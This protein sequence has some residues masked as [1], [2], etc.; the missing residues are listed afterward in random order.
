M[1]SG[2]DWYK[3]SFVPEAYRHSIEVLDTNG[4]VVVHIGRYGNLDS[5]DGPKSRI[6]VGVRYN[7]K[8]WIEKY[9]RI[10]S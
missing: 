8:L 3:R 6:S 4:N 1:R 9:E 5:C 2:L 10:L 7:R